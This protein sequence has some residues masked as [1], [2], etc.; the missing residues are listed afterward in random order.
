MDIEDEY[1]LYFF[2]ATILD[3]I[4]VLEDD[5]NK[6]I[7]VSSL[8][9]L[10]KQKRIRVFAFVVMPNHVHINWEIL[11]KHKKEDVQRDFLKYTAQQIKFRLIETKSPLLHLLE[12]NL[13]DRKYQIWQ[14]NALSI[15]LWTNAVIEQKIDYIHENP[16]NGKWNLSETPEA[17]KYSSAQF[18]I[19]NTSD[20][21]FLTHYMDL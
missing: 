13:K 11:E 14:R 9:F 6:D 10:V 2:T 8:R 17:Y 1:Q 5:F 3:W 20:F 18:Y 7:I 4:H 15:P 16:L 21:D 19:E 12:V